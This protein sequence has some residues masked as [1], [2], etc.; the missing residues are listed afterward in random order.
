MAGIL[1]DQAIKASQGGKRNAYYGSG[2]YFTDIA[3]EQLALGRKADLSP[4]QIASGA[5]TR[6]MLQRTLFGL[7]WGFSKYTND[8]LEVNLNNLPVTQV[9][10]HKFLVPNDLPLPVDGR[11][12]SSGPTIFHP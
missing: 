7:P 2:Q 1:T 10:T 11:I 8:Y 3:P 9:D 6:G 4:A 5:M 12:R